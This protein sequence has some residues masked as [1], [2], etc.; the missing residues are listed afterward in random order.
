MTSRIVEAA[1]AGDAE[2]VRRLSKC[3]NPFIPPPHASSVEPALLSACEFGQLAVVKACLDEDLR[4]NPN[5]VD[6]SGRSPLHMAVVRRNGKVAVSILRYLSEKGA[7]MRKSVLHV[8]VNELAVFPLIELGADVNA[9]S[10]DGLTPIKVAVS[11]DRNDMVSELIRARCLV[12]PECMFLAKS[13]SVIQTLVRAGLDV[14]ISSSG[15]TPLQKAVQG[16]NKKLARSLLEA[17]ADPSLVSLPP[18]RTPSVELASCCS[19]E[20][21]SRSV[22]NEGFLIPLLLLKSEE[23]SQLVDRIINSAD[24]Q[25]G[26][27]TETEFTKL[28]SLHQSISTKLTKANEIA[29]AV[30]RNFNGFCIICRSEPKSIVL[31][32]C[33]HMCCCSACAASLL[34]TRK[35]PVCRA[36]VTD[37]V[38]VFT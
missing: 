3:N 36:L 5:C 25:L 13:A 7:K 27:S 32:P 24:S 4:C 18:T 37:T 30:R 20:D 33:K 16:N 21:L 14:N 1:I 38:A 11:A 17:K 22:S 31:M 12:P 6:R 10:V 29:I 35:C 2:E 34:E 15:L 23:M 9:V 26:K 19:S 28:L 8:C